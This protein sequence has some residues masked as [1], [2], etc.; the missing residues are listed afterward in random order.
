MPTFIEARRIILQHVRP[1]GSERRSLLEAAGRVIAEEVI[2]PREMPQEDNSAMD[3][4][5]VR[6]ADCR[7]PG[8]VLRLCGYLPA[9]ASAVGVAATPGTAVKIM[10]GAPIPHGA[11]AVVPFEKT[12][13]YQDTVEIRISV[14]AGDHIR[15]RGEDIA[16]GETVIPCGTVLR[17]P[18]VGLLASFGRVMVPVFRR[19]R[20]AILSTGDELVEA[21]EVPA[22]GKIVNSNSLALAAALQEI[23]AEPILLG[24]ARDN[25]KCHLEKI[26]EG[27]RADALVTSAGVSTGDRDLVRPV[28]AELGV[29]PVFRTVKIRPGRPTAFGIKGDVPVFSLPGNPV[30][31]MI[32]FEEFVRPA[33]L[34]MMGHRRV[35]KPLLRA[36]LQEE[37]RKKPGRLQFLRVRVEVR[38]G[39]YLATTSGD[40]N[41]GILKSMVR[42]DGLALLPEEAEFFAAGE[43]VGVHLLGQDPVMLEE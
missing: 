17:P 7:E 4:Y 26:S 14:R 1:L 25:R 34:K 16:A 20:V 29:E 43:R 18:E 3:G 22:P 8:A 40:Q 6:A 30:A 27:L 38:D 12:A 36:V 13:E 2:A 28:L 39:D 35:V 5:A 31:T 41:T 42:A 21:G 32:T 19:A 33:L 10:T 37:V 9:G 11:D 24:I 15:V 23:G